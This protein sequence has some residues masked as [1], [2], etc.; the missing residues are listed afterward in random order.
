MT[1]PVIEFR[2]LREPPTTS[3]IESAKKQ[4]ARNGWM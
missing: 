1:T 4:L 3:D 2:L